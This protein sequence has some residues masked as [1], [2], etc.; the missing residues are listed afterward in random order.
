MADYQDDPMND[1]DEDEDYGQP[2]EPQTDAG[3]SKGKTREDDEEMEGEY[4]ERE[5][6]DEED[7]EDDEEDDEEEDV[8]PKGK[9]RRKVRVRS[10][11]GP[12]RPFT[13]ALQQRHKRSAVS[14]F[15]DVE[16]EVSDEDEEDEDEDEDAGG[17]MVHIVPIRPGTDTRLSL[18]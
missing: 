15:L 13:Y 3:R 8:G 11:K 12:N 4:P 14:R 7:D 18:H 6:D 10:A 16:A 5:D 9:K 2:R 17:E 1:F